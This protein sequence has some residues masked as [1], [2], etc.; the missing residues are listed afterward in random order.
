[1]RGA[2]D[3]LTFMS[4]SCI[5]SG[6]EAS[7]RIMKAALV[8]QPDLSSHRTDREMRALVSPL[9]PRSD[10]FIGTFPERRGTD[11][12]FTFISV[13]YTILCSLLSSSIM[14]AALMHED[15]L[16]SLRTA[17]DRRASERLVMSS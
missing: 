14:K 12:L 5:V 17:R 11:G 6:S 2:D 9:E 15:A 1:M 4:L 10:G 3:L 7:I 16:P 13:C 8:H